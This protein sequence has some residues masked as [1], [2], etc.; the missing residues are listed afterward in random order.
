MTLL[1]AAAAPTNNVTAIYTASTNTLN[2]VGDAA[3]NM[4]TITSQNGVYTLSG[5]N[6]TKI[7][8]LALW[9]FN[10]NGFINITG[11]LGDGNDSITILNTSVNVP[12]LQLGSGN[13]TFT[14]ANSK[15]AIVT[16]DG[17]LG[18]DTFV[19]KGGAYSIQ[20]LLSFP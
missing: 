5:S 15:T 3:N 8:G 9:S 14:T 17:G 2:I 7:N 19:V 20:N 11:N 10:R 1:T 6:G 13:D 16:L 12:S 18:T 4:L